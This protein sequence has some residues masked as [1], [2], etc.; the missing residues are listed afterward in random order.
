MPRSVIASILA[1]A[2]GALLP[3]SLDAQLPPAGPGGA[4]ASLTGMA[5][6]TITAAEIRDPDSGGL[7]YCYARGIL[8]PAIG[9][10]MQLPLPD[11]WNGRFL[12]WGDGG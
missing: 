5:N 1:V 3:A 4:C 6:L 2:L 8:P 10:H 9:F 11:Q 7:P 12:K